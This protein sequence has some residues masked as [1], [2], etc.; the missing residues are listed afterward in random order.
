MSHKPESHS[1]RRIVLPVDVRRIVLPTGQSIDLGG[2]SDE[3][4]SP[5]E[6]LDVCP[7]CSSELVQPVQW[8][9]ND[10]G[11]W[12]LTLEC[13]NC[14]WT[15]EGVFDADQ[16]EA[17]EDRLEDGVAVLLSDLR[18]LT[19]ANMTEEIER[20]VTALEADWILPEDF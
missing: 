13:P 15:T 17:F 19:Q 3:Q 14:R 2:R 10:R 6:G 11:S 5:V 7:A 20:F 1:A 12:R 4:A 8:E 16:M 9:A 18:Q